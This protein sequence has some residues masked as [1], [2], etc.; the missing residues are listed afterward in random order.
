MGLVFFVSESTLSG[1]V[2][3]PTVTTTPTTVTSVTSTTANGSYLTGQ[4]ISIQ[5]NFSQPVT[6]TGTPMLALNSGGTASYTSGSGTS[7]LTFTYIIGTADTSNHLDYSS[8]SAL[9]L[10]GGTITDGELNPAVLTLAAPGTAGS[11]GANTNFAINLTYTISGEV[12]FS[13][14]GTPLSGVTVTLTGSVSNNYSL[15]SS[16]L[17]SFAVPANGTYTVTPSRSG[18][19]FSPLSQTFN[20]LSANQTVNFTG[21]PTNTMYTISGQVTSSGA[22]LSNVTV[23]LSGAQS[24]STRPPTVRAITVLP[25]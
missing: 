19:T 7:T 6:V 5:V 25:T 16:G 12:T 14:N 3:V 13:T 11:L 9:T 17:Y 15:N 10:N 24:G 23:T 18:Y 4:A 2:P 1:S 22:A 8:T 21:T 20:S